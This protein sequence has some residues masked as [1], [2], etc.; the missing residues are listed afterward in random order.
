MAALIFP[1][2]SDPQP[3]RSDGSKQAPPPGSDALRLTFEAARAGDAAALDALCRAMRPRLLRTAYAVLH[4][5]DEADDVAQD[6]LVRALARRWLFLGR[7]SVA[8][9]MTR[10]ALNLA[11][12]RRRDAARRQEILT[13]AL[14]DEAAVRGAR[15]SEPARADD[16]L[17]HAE[18]RSALLRGL[19]LLS[20]R[21]RDVVRLRAIA[22]FEFRDVAMTLRMSEANVRVTFSQARKRLLSGMAAAP[23]F[24]TDAESVVPQGGGG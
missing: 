17:L 22:G 1:A 21:Q 6:A 10:I 12:N 9:W 23:S 19:E 13:T 18:E 4:D 7:G 11:K 20:D 15:A 14:P 5:A 3:K 8:G 2:K 16:A 24:R